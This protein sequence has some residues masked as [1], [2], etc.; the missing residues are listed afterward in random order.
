MTDVEDE[1]I[2]CRDHCGTRTVFRELLK[3]GKPY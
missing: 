1:R 2:P 3:E